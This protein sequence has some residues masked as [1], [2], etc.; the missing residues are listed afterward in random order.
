MT[1]SEPVADASTSAGAVTLTV[2]TQ[3]A[4]AYPTIGEAL[5]AAPDGATLAVAAGT[6]AEAL[7][8]NGVSATI[9]AAEGPGTVVIDVGT[10][11]YP[12]VSCA[13]GT[14]VL[15]DVT[16]RSGDAPVVAVDRGRLHADRCDLVTRCDVGVRATNRS[17]VELTRLKVHGG[18]YGLVIDDSGGS[19]TDCEIADV[20]GDGVIVR[21]GADPLIR[22]CSVRN[23]GGRG[24]YV[25]QF[26]RPTIEG[27]VISEVGAAGIAV[28]HESRPT[29]RRSR[30][31]RSRGPG[32]TFGPG[33]VGLVEDCSF[34][35][36]GVVEI[37]VA[38]GAEPVVRLLD[39]TRAAADVADVAF[40][41]EFEQQLEE[42]E[43]MIGLADVKE[44]IRSLVDEIQVNEWRR[45]CG[46]N[47]GNVNHHLIFAGPPGTGKT[48]V[49]RIYGSLLA[50]LN[51]LPDGGF[52]EVSRQD[53]VVGYL[54]QT[55]GKTTEVFK[56]ALGGVLFIDE[57][58]TLARV[59]GAGRDF[60]QEAIDTLVKLMED[61]RGEIVVIAAGY[62][63]E[64]ADFLAVNPGLASRFARTI[65]FGNYSPGELVEIAHRM[66]GA[67][68]YTLDPAL[69]GLLH[70][71]FEGLD[72]GGAFGN[73][74]EV[75]TLVDGMRRAQARRLRR[76]GRRP[77]LS[78]L[79]MMVPADFAA[80]TPP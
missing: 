4:D 32:I 17:R 62:T 45:A 63:G 33:C 80:A 38:S 44:D 68:D 8:V 7:Y 9:V 59:I 67:S 78:A 54:G 39:A 3:R 79:R 55:A 16:L 24:F 42:L 35:E 61:H 11:P 1:A 31:E 6:Y 50:A 70:R 27:C 29:I 22:D 21:H 49:A 58:Y 72:R 75:R 51:V 10:L 18:Q 14:V 60:G 47:V 41:E 77:D 74:R 43:S 5:S 53:L 12:A 15:R 46:L 19:I 30:V 69:D 37:D 34:T 48:T 66:A 13:G 40:A 56:S 64:M 73:A 23:C 28:V 52:V 71:H 25:Y 57:A 26:G 2:G 36:V 65:T 76:A 20:G